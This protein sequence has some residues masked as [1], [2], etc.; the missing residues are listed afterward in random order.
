MVPVHAFRLEPESPDG[1]VTID[2]E[3]IDTGV[4][5]DN[6]NVSYLTVHDCN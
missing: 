4:G 2:G 3:L 6:D 1:R 5:G